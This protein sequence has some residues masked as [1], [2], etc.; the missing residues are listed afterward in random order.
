MSEVGR[1]S[2]EPFYPRHSRSETEALFLALYMMGG[3]PS[4]FMGRRLD[5]VSPHLDRL[6][7]AG[8]LFH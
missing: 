2:V 8:H 3:I 5:G 1:D 4:H 7:V 6:I